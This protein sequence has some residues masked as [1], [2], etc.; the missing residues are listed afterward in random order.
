MVSS[1]RAVI[2]STRSGR[3]YHLLI[4]KYVKSRLY[5]SLPSNIHPDGGF[6]PEVWFQHF[7]MHTKSVNTANENAIVKYQTYLSKGK[8]SISYVT[9]SVGF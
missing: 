8:V 7:W 4:S 1:I 5:A 6:L 3:K 9:I 2:A